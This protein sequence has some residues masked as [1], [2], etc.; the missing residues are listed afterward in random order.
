MASLAGDKIAERDSTK[1]TD[2]FQRKSGPLGLK[3]FYLDETE[4][5]YTCWQ[6]LA[7]NEYLQVLWSR[8]QRL[9]KMHARNRL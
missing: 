7:K 6:S 5:A 2:E 9:A 4:N 3:T 8:E 1:K